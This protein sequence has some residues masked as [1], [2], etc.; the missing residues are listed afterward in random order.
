MVE[1]KD[2]LLLSNQ[3]KP[4]VNGCA[5]SNVERLI[6]ACSTTL[7]CWYSTHL[8]APCK[9]ERTCK[10]PYRLRSH[11][12][13]EMLTYCHAPAHSCSRLIPCEDRALTIRGFFA[14]HG[15]RRDV[16]Y[17][18]SMDPR[19]GTESRP[20]MT[21]IWRDYHRFSYKCALSAHYLA[22]SCSIS[23]CTKFVQYLCIRNAKILTLGILKTSFSLH[24]LNRIFAT[25]NV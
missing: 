17:F 8:C 24:S 22:L 19:K 9:Q 14:Q 15:A 20:Q 7:N 6:P 16:K 2:I 21:Q 10:Y 25:S 12:A 13:R 1:C 18:H 11:I 4:N 5:P 23:Q 3:Q